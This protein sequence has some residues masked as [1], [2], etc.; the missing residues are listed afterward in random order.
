MMHFVR[1]FSI[2]RAE[3]VKAYCNRRGFK[4][5][6]IVNIKNMFENG[7]WEDAYLSPCPLGHKLQKPSKEFSI[8][9]FLGTI[10]FV[11]FY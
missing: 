5:W 11:L 6:K 2:M 7:W 3:G 1:T 10:S 8:F 9:Q 4:L